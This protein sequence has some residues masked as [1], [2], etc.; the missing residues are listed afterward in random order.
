MQRMMGCL[1][2]YRSVVV[3]LLLLGIPIFVGGQDVGAQSR[4]APILRPVTPERLANAEAEPQN[5]LMYSGGY[6]S[7][8]YSRLDQIDRGSVANLR[9][10][11]VHQLQTLDRAE[12]TPLVADGMMFVT[13]SPSS[14]IALDAKTGRPYLAI[15]PRA[16]RGAGLLLRAQ[17]PRRCHPG[18]SAVHEHPGCACGGTRCPNRER[19][20]GR[21]GGGR[22]NGLQ[23][24]R[25]AAGRRQ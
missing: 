17:Q 12:T 20:V 13:E 18:R 4:E 8:R 14:V 9:V 16:T 15:Q 1:M 24:D 2:T 10:H 23:H 7:Q 22:E 11:W 3:A 5:W 19:A 6:K 25:G 21:R